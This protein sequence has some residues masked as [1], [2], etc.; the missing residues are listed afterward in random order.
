MKYADDVFG[1]IRSMSKQEKRYFKLYATAFTRSRA[2][3]YTELF[4][5]IDRQP[6]L[7]E[8][9]LRHRFQGRPG[10]ANF[11]AA[12]H[13]LCRLLLDSLAAYSAEAS[14]AA[15]LRRMLAHI[16]VLY[17]KG[18][19]A[20]CGRLIRRAIRKAER[21]EELNVLLQLLHWER[22]LL[23]RQMKEGL[24]DEL[25][26]NAGHTKRSLQRIQT[27]IASLEQAGLAH[28]AIHRRV[29]PR[30]DEEREEL[31]RILAHPLLRS[32]EQVDSFSARHAL[33]KVLASSELLRGDYEAALLRH[34]DIVELWRT[35]QDQLRDHS[36]TYTA[37]ICNF[38]TCCIALKRDEDFAGHLAAIKAI[39]PKSLAAE[40]HRIERIYF[41]ELSYHLNTGALDDALRVLPAIEEGITIHYDRILPSRRLILWLNC[42][43]ACFLSGQYSAVVAYLINILNEKPT[44]LRRDIQEC[45]R[46]LRLLAHYEL[47]D[48]D[49]LD[50]ML[51]STRDYLRKQ[52]PLLEFERRILTFVRQLLSSADRQATEALFN[53]LY[54][55]LLDL[56]HSTASAQ[57]M[58]VFETLFW[59]ESKRRNKD[60]ASVFCDGARPGHMRDAI[61]MFPKQ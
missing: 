42:A 21:Y 22:R 11:A 41:L 28:T 51:R 47:G 39:R 14:A 17:R 23:L 32:P 18:L 25:A 49:L 36:D 44:E 15:E 58:G 59:L 31:Q 10:M 19:Y 61:E 7:D 38:L 8:A 26:R 60:I 54:R 56:L 24:S 55:E 12:K 43:I 33:L 13:R 53:N 57:P 37:D 46:V 20:H 16:E 45:A 3:A 4:D 35:H 52:T 5:A 30:G 48:Y 27:T 40:V 6:A 29:A 1:L 34:R 9:A 50:R 2:T